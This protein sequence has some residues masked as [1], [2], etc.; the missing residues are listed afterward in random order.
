MLAGA[1]APDA[2][3]LWFYYVEK[4][5][6]GTPEHA[7]WRQAYYRDTW[8]TFIDLFNSVPGIGVG[9]LMCWW[10]RSR[11]GLLFLASMLLHV[12]LDFPLHHDDGHRHFHPL[13]DWRF[14]SPLSY[15]DPKHH[16]SL[17]GIGELVVS[18][19][20]VAVVYV[21]DKTRFSRWSIGLS[22]AAY[23]GYYAFA[24]FMWSGG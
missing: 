6:L 23:A 11:V 7:I 8:Q 22:V 2:P 14:Q 20:C 16:G 19:L 12:A 10:L 9:L 24:V 1:V 4:V 15:W 21:Y 18:V 13:L 17:I 5:L 3:M